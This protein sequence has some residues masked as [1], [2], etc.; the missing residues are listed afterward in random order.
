MSQLRHWL[1]LRDFDVL[2]QSM[3]ALV[4]LSGALPSL[5]LACALS[6]A[7]AQHA[8]AHSGG[9]NRQGCH[10]GSQPYHCHRAESQPITGTPRSADRGTRRRVVSGI[11]TYVRDGDT[12][13]L[14]NLPIRLAAVDCPESNTQ[15]GE[16]AALFLRQYISARVT[17]E[18]TGATTYDRSVAYCSIDGRDIGRMLF[19]NTQCRVW[20][21]YDVWDRY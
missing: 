20:A 2:E 11:V 18:L 5:L 13:L 7:M 12:F 10:S 21:Q 6:L 15:A 14:G 3:R 1:F 19:A 9:L 4:L 16:R 17:C 8:D